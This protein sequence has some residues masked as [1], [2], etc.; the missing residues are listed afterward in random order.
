MFNDLLDDPDLSE[1][2]LSYDK[3][4][5]VGMFFVSS[6]SFRQTEFEENPIMP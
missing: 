6:L 1:E 5:N 3:T 2:V 4:Y